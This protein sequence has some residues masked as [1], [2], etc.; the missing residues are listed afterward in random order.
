MKSVFV[1]KKLVLLAAFFCATGALMAQVI[2][3]NTGNVGIG[4]STPT[5][6]LDVLIPDLATMESGIRI[7]A[8]AIFQ[9]GSTIGDLFRIRKDVFGGGAP[10]TL[11]SVGHN[12]KVSIG[13]E[14]GTSTYV[15]DYKLYVGSGILTEKVKIANYNSANW[16]D[17]VFEDS[18]DLMALDNLEAYIATHKHL[19]NIPSAQEVGENGFELG[20]MDARLLEKIEELTLYVIEQ[21]K[22]INALETKL[23][24][25]EK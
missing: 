23:K 20:Q 11:F 10:K 5:A 19:P 13:L 14:P 4:Q 25:L 2:P 9:V 6:K 18:Y 15:G 21:Q 7:H 1:M 8:P 3:S 17:Y 24:S 22:Q 16:A 12:G